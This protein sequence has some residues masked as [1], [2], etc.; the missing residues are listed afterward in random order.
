MA[1][2][3]APTVAALLPESVG[4]PVARGAAIAVRDLN[5]AGGLR[6]V[7]RMPPPAANTAVSAATAFRDDDQVIGVIGPTGSRSVLD[8][9][10]VY[11]DL[12]HD[13]TRG[14]VAISPTATSPVLSGRSPWLF[15]VCPDDRAASR[16]AAQ[17][18]RDS[19]HAR[20]AAVIYRNDVYGK[21]WSR[22]FAAAFTAGG[23]SVVLREPEAAMLTEWAGPYATYAQSV[24]AD[25]LVIAG[26]A[27]DA[28]PLVRAARAAGLDVPVIG[29][30]A[31]SD[32]QDPATR[33]EIG[34]IRYTSLFDA[35]RAPAGIERHF[36]DAYTAAYGSRPGQEA[37]LAYDAALLLGHAARAVGPDRSAVRSYLEGVG[38]TRSAFVGAT[39]SIAF[40]ARHDVVDKP[41]MLTFVRDQ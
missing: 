16:A 36:V 9:M 33:R 7:L 41:I 40:D 31:L 20:R 10:P 23:G 19:L 37:A 14:L 29:S 18:A 38:R 22:A 25:V 5:R 17:F 11:G 3:V 1:I 4:S 26:G 24:G 35:R 6:F 39:G 12:E 32:I 27:P 13:G 15:R 21:G 2:G 30:D 8:A 34:S 28:V